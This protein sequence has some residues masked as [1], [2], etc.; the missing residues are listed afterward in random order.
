MGRRGD[1]AYLR[2]EQH[3]AAR[4]AGFGAPAFDLAITVPGLPAPV[5]ARQVAQAYLTA[6]GVPPV[7]LSVEVLARVLAALNAG[8]SFVDPC[9]E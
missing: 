7:V 6:G 2:G 8:G 4:K 1:S 9:M 3:R 5:A